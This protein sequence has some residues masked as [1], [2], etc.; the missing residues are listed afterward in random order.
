MTKWRRQEVPSAPPP[1]P[2]APAPVRCAIRVPSYPSPGGAQRPQRKRRRTPRQPAYQ[3]SFSPLARGQAILRKHRTAEKNQLHRPAP[4]PLLPYAAQS[5]YRAT[6]PPAGRNGPSANGAARPG[7]P[8]TK[9]AFP[10][11]PEDKQSYANIALPK[12][13]TSATR[14]AAQIALKPLRLPL[15]GTAVLNEESHPTS[16]M[17]DQDSDFDED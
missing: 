4:G 8:P 17:I 2:R 6:R 15:Q 16:L 9:K 3:K 11:S 1:R 13:T 5:A 12:K 14:V 10:R 7:S